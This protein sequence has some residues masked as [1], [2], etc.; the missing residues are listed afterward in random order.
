MYNGDS[1]FASSASN[2]VLQTVVPHAPAN[3]NA[4]AQVFTHS[5]EHYIDF[6]TGLYRAYLRRAADIP[7]LNGWISALSQR[8]ITD[9]QATA[10]FLG[11]PEYV[12]NH[13]GFTNGL[14]DRDWVIG[15]YH[16]VLNRTPSD[17]EI[18]NWLGALA[19]GVSTMSIALTFTASP[20]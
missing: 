7:G 10:D 20:E 9:E 11:A 4:V 14:P 15:L 5:Q 2:T 8:Q 18:Q 6:V 12:N 19:H 16:D 17:T 1:N 13:G 3:L